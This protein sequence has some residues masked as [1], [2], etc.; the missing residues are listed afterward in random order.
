MILDVFCYFLLLSWNCANIY[1]SLAFFFPTSRRDVNSHAPFL[2]VFCFAVSISTFYGYLNVGELFDDPSGS[3]ITCSVL[4]YYKKIYQ[5][6]V[7]D[8]HCVYMWRVSL[9]ECCF[10]LGGLS[11]FWIKVQSIIR[12]K[13][14]YRHDNSTS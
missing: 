14:A 11:H 12:L 3:R 5:C 8:S 6:H 2:M 1:C 7:N 10:F 4:I 13:W 9:V